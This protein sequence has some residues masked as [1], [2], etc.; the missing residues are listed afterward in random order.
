MV[1][2]L[3]VSE[4]FNPAGIPRDRLTVPV[5]FAMLETRITDEPVLLT[6]NLTAV[7]FVVSE[8]SGVGTVSTMVR[9]TGGTTP[10]V[11]VKFSR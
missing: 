8:K 4:A 1:S 7:G 5:K 9:R 10:L 2:C 11:A 6:L 3:A